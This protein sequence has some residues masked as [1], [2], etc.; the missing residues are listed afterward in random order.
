MAIAPNRAET[1]FATALDLPVSDRAAFLVRECVGNTD[2]RCEVES[3]LAA[4]G[5]AGAFLG[6]PAGR[7]PTL[8]VSAAE[9]SSL[10]EQNGQH[11]DRLCGS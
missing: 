9:S 7:E 3:L 1:I 2:L 6:Q 11:V 5:R 8:E 10:S 4:D